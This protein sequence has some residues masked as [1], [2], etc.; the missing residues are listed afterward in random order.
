MKVTTKNSLYHR[1]CVPIHAVHK[2]CEGVPISLKLGICFEVTHKK[3]YMK[4]HQAK[5]KL[6]VIR[7]KEIYSQFSVVM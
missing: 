6:N 1:G 5:L 3:R 2:N 7:F 4:Y